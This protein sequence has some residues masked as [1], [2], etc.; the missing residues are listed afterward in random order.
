MF[1]KSFAR[2]LYLVIAAVDV[3]VIFFLQWLSWNCPRWMQVYRSSVN[4]NYPS[5][6]GDTLVMSPIVWVAVI[7]FMIIATFIAAQIIDENIK[8]AR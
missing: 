4:G 3:G 2:V 7:V 5:E 6:A 1:S 8:R